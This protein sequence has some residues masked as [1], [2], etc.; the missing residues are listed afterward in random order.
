V[1]SRGQFSQTRTLPESGQDKTYRFDPELEREREARKDFSMSVDVLFKLPAKCVVISIHG[2]LAT[3]VFIDYH[4]KVRQAQLCQVA[5]SRG[6]TF[7][8]KI[9]ALAKV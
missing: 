1:P 7:A 3:F 5:M 4:I 2:V 9:W 8:F 6:G